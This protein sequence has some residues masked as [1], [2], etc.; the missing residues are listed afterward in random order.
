MV[1]LTLIVKRHDKNTYY[2]VRSV[3]LFI[4]F[5]HLKFDDQICLFVCC[6]Q[7]KPILIFFFQIHYTNIIIITALKFFVF[8]QR[9][10]GVEA[11]QSCFQLCS[12]PFFNLTQLAQ[13][14]STH[15]TLSSA[16]VAQFS[17]LGFSH[18]AQKNFHHN[19]IPEADGA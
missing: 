5:R 15:C 6:V 16:Q 17:Q 3:S 18:G 7:V 11:A 1:Y 9:N 19:N 14:K 2:V 13:C 12:D 10:L 4:H 8:H